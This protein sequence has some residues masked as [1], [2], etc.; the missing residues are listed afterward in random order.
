MVFC[1]GEKNFALDAA[2]ACD[3]LARRRRADATTR[4]RQKFRDRSLHVS[5]AVGHLDFA[6]FARRRF[7]PRIREAHLKG[8]GSRALPHRF[9]QTHLIRGDKCSAHKR[10]E[11][12]AQIF[13]TREE[14]KLV[15]GDHAG[16]GDHAGFVD[17]VLGGFRSRSAAV[18]PPISPKVLLAAS[19]EILRIYGRSFGTFPGD[20]TPV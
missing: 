3:T 2:D 20:E 9:S 6:L 19:L 5:D 1:C 17:L 4:R 10:C 15:Q 11:F 8:A 14:I 13:S 7:A 16:P 18:R 12:G